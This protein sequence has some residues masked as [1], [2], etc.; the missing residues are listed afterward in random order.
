MNA[1]RSNVRTLDRRAWKVHEAHQAKGATPPAVEQLAEVVRELR[2][3]LHE[4]APSWY[5]P[6]QHSRVES[7]IQRISER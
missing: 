7:A 1:H 4:Y 2:D 5:S 6:E 3:L